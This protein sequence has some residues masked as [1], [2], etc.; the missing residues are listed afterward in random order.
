MKSVVVDYKSGEPI[1]TREIRNFKD[2]NSFEAFLALCLKNKEKA[3][4]AEKED[5]EKA[6]AIETAKE[7]KR[8]AWVARLWLEHELDNGSHEMT[9]GEYEAFLE[10]FNMG[11]V[12]DLDTMPLP[13]LA[14]YEILRG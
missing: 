3:D 9:E 4:K 7:C 12:K 13:F 8:C 6:Q 14:V 1:S 2:E 11:D 10:N 5:K